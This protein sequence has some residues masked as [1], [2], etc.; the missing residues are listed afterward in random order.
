VTRLAFL[1][2]SG[3]FTEEAILTQPD[4]ATLDMVPMRTMP[5]VLQAV[6]DGSVD[7]GFLPIENAIEGTVNLT[8]D[9]LVFDHD[10]LIQREVVLPIHLHLAA[11]ATSTLG[12]IKRVHSFPVALAQ[13]RLYLHETLPDAEQIGA[14]ST[15][16]AARYVAELG[17]TGDAAIC[18]ALAAKQYGLAVLATD[19]EDHPDNS[20]RFLLI[21]REGIPASTGHDKTVV[22]CYQSEDRPGSLQGMLAEFSARG[23]NLVK[24]ESR[25]TKQSLGSYCFIIELEGHIDDEVVADAL[26]SVRSMHADVKFLGSFPAAGADGPMVRRDAKERWSDAHDW[27]QKL[28]SQ[29]R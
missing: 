13:S 23:I 5:D 1:G 22:V 27:L 6:A 10:L 19:I 14:S 17:L 29:V 18:P 3:T 24:L 16:E 7:V 26:M 11:P 20:T 21:G 28:R 4:L 2:P 9:G 15:A 12:D 8:L 25:T